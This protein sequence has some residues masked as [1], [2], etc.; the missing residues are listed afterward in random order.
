MSL[1]IAIDTGG[2]FTDLV[3]LDDHA[4]RLVF[5]KVNSTPDDPERALVQGVVEILEKAGAAKSSIRILV[6]GT[7]VATNTV[8]QRRGAVTAFIT[9]EGFRDILHIQRQDRPHLY[10]LRARRARPL[11][12]RYLRF[13]LPE[14]ILYDGTVHQPID[15]SRLDAI[16][17]RLNAE[18]VQAAAVGLLNSH[19]NP[20]H[21]KAVGAALRRRLPDLPVC[22]SHELT[23]EE[24]EYERFSTCV[25]NA[26][27]QP[28]I[29]RYLSRLGRAVDDAGI[30]A[31]LFV[32]KS[33]GGVMSADDAARQC[34]H[35]ML[36]GPAGGVVAGH[37]MAEHAGR[38]H[39]ITADMGGTSFDVSMI[40]AGQI[41]FARDAEIEGLALKVPMLDIHTVGAGGG[42]IGWIDAGGAL[43]I[44]PHSAGAEPGPACYGRGG[45]Q[46]TVTDANLVLG[47]LAEN[48]LLDGGMRLDTEAARRAIHDRL[49]TPLGLSVEATAEGMIRVVNATMTAAIRKLTIERG[50]DPRVFT[51]CAFGGAG[52]LHAAELARELNVQHALIP[53]APGVASAMGLLMSPLREDRVRTEVA[54]LSAM[55]ADRLASICDE[56]LMDAREALAF[57]DREYPIHVIRKLGLRYYR[58][59][60]DLQVDLPEGAIDPARIA[61]EFHAAHVRAYG[62]ARADQPV[63]LSHVWVSVQLDMGRVRLPEIGDATAEA[64]PVSTRRVVFAGTVHETSVYRRESLGAGTRL[65]GPA[66]V[67]QLDSTALIWPDQQGTVDRYG[68]IILGPIGS[69]SR[70]TGSGTAAATSPSP[71]RR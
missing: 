60:Y 66:I 52:P 61:D 18:G 48:T 34:V 32:M 8:L 22:L 46:P 38:P 7:T 2:T 68:Q 41:T 3:L 54:L 31:P 14:R 27:V 55:P 1:R 63:Q 57:P 26:Y 25:M 69:L 64:E 5:H 40:Y 44:G 49:A 16:L 12:P 58:Q 19:I 4:D 62:Y 21:E 37:I 45:D 50:Y 29:S 39:I 20:V 33:N 56:L 9:T 17:D 10:N 53:R 28:V 23:Q 13:E 43:R 51:L 6:H 65:S 36:S 47:R 24:G 30:R 59:G 67:E 70:A 35:T 15:K 11:V 42:S 71:D